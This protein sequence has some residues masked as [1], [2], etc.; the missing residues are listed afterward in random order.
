[1]R[2]DGVAFT[3]GSKSFFAT[4]GSIPVIRVTTSINALKQKRD[5]LKNLGELLS[6]F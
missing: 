5:F 4:A 6:S 3:S 2:V 1:L